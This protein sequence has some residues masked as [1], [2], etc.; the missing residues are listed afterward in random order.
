MRGLFLSWAPFSRRTETLARHFGLEARFV[1]SP[2]P[3]RPLAIPLKYPV[4]ALRTVLVLARDKPDEIW[5]MDPPLPA[6]LLAWRRA[7]RAH[8]PLVVDVHTV[9]FYAPEWRAL[10]RFE[11]PALRAARA[12][13]V[14]NES[15]ART[16]R[17]WGAPALVLPD[18]LPEP[19]A[20]GDETIDEDL[21]TVVATYSKDE[22]LAL[23]PEA[24][25]SL[26]D[27]EFRVTGAP[28]GDLS[29]WPAN[30]QATGFLDDGEYWRQLA[31]SAVVAVLTTR[32]DTL[33]SG[34]YEALALER[35]LVVSDHEVLR[36]YFADAAVYAE[37]SAAGVAAAVADALARRDQLAGRMRELA[38][39]RRAEWQAAARRLERLVG[40][41]EEAR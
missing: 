8:R 36:D 1:S 11:K 25:R 30:L 10:R 23:L 3:K 27:V 16:V 21:V 33:L 9:G 26:P 17:S 24:A 34:G 5:V 15:L 31:R 4:Q 14:T 12:V 18:P 20:L 6:V 32:P 2:W 29:G 39:R 37:A 28:R 19:P 38:P 41:G 35:P 40:R 22:P 13:V 7:R